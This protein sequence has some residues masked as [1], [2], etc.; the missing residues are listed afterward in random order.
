MKQRRQEKTTTRGYGWSHQ[1]KR[2]R[3]A[4]RVAKGE[5]ICAR[6]RRPIV[7]WESWDLGHRDGSGKREYSGPEHSRCNRATATHKAKRKR[8]VY[9][10]N[11]A[12]RR[13][14]VSRDW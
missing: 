9:D 11:Y 14:C 10:P 3:W 4:K 1:Q 13:C 5:A 6:C 7:P 2:A 12:E 8:P